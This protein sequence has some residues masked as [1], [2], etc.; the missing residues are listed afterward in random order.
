MR[1][2]SDD[3]YDSTKHGTLIYITALTVVVMYS[4]SRLLWSLYMLSIGLCD[5]IGAVP[6]FNVQWKQVN[7]ITD[8]VISQFMW[9]NYW[10]P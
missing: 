2:N 9:S 6:N 3:K 8:N 7:V 10:S 4:G 1:K 5:Q